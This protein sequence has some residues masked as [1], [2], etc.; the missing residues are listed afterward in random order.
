M[1]FRFHPL[2]LREFEEAALY[3]EQRQAGLGERYT[4]AIELAIAGILA[5]PA[6]WPVLEG[7][8]VG[9]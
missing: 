9:D 7:P 4:A 6:M 3:Y 8:F 5:A 1:K 2:A